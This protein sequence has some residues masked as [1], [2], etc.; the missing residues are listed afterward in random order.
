[1]K[2]NKFS[3]G[4]TTYHCAVCNRLTRYTGTQSLGSE[5]CSQCYEIAGYEN[6]VSDGKPVESVRAAVLALANEVRAKGGTPDIAFVL[7]PAV[8]DRI[9]QQIG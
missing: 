6:D 8:T 7:K 5:L 2:T 4:Q 1:M 3:R 9:W